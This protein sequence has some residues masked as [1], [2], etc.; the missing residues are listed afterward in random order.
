MCLGPYRWLVSP[1]VLT[2]QRP[3]KSIVLTIVLTVKRAR[4]LVV[5]ANAP[6]ILCLQLGSP[7]FAMLLSAPKRLTG[8]NCILGVTCALVLSMRSPGR[9]SEGRGNNVVDICFLLI[10]CLYDG[11]RLAGSPRHVTCQLLEGLV[12]CSFRGK[13]V[14]GIMALQQSCQQS[15]EQ[16]P[17]GHTA[18]KS[19][20]EASL[21]C[22]LFPPNWEEM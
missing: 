12:F 13:N 16:A 9:K 14:R 18:F 3:L 2:I 4:D 11:F 17:R 5:K 6:D 1:W 7:F 19:Y 8:M 20:P 10:S 15:K 21:G 22:F